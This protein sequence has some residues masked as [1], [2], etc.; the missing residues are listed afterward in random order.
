MS[1]E[2]G[3]N[4]LPH[5]GKWTR[6]TG[7]VQHTIMIP[8]KERPVDVENFEVEKKI[9]WVKPEPKLPPAPV[10]P[11]MIPRERLEMKGMMPKVAPHAAWA[12]IEKRIIAKT[13]MGSELARPS[14]MQKTPPKVW[15]THRVQSLPLMPNNLAAT[16]EVYPPKGR[17]RRFAIPNEAAM[18]PAVC[19]FRLNLFY[20]KLTTLLKQIV[21]IETILNKNINIF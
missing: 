13:A 12:P 1:F 21:I 4:M 8:I 11:D 6:V 15:R 5:W 19:S 16:S 14:H 3:R 10:R 9:N 20:I 2:G 17:A 18:I 7:R